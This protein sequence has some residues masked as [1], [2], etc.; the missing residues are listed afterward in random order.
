MCIC[1]MHVYMQVYM[2]YVCVCVWQNDP[3][4]NRDG[5]TRLVDTLQCH[6]EGTTIERRGGRKR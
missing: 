1:N 6:V 4:V 3:T 2:M 5:V